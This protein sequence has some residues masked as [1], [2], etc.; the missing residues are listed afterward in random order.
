MLVWPRKAV[1]ATV[2]VKKR[3]K[4]KR[5]NPLQLGSRLQFDAVV[6]EAVNTVYY[7]YLNVL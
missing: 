2:K 6:F 5:T 1:S 7:T 3:M 4:V